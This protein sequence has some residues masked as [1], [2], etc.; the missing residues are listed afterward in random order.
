MTGLIA[1]SGNPLDRAGNQRHNAAWLASL[2]AGP[3]ASVLP[4]WKL[5]PLLAT[6][7]GSEGS[8]RLGFIDGSIASAL[9]PDSSVEVFLGLRG[10]Q[11]YFARDISAVD[12]PVAG[13]LV[14]E[15][16]LRG[17]APVEWARGKGC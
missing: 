10:Q 17:A 16:A 11:A 8:A 15:P 4:L 12:D 1:F 14:A 7:D 9:G 6:A 5:Q 13:T 2:R 3:H